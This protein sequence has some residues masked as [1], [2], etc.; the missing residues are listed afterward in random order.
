M[1]SKALDVVLPKKEADPY[2]DD[3]SYLSKKRFLIRNSY[4]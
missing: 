1:F 2:M 3:F 4:E